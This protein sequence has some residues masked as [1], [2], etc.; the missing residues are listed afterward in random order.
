MN[1]LTLNLPKALRLTDEEFE[2]LAAA[3]ETCAWSVPH[4]RTDHHAAIWGESKR[5]AAD[6]VN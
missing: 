4:R 5:T 3:T 2:Q 1:A 6:L